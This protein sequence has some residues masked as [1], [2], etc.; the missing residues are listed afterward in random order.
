MQLKKWG[1][2]LVS[3]LLAAGL[4]ACGGGGSNGNN[5]SQSPPASPS[6]SV[7]AEETGDEALTPEPGAK[8]KVWEGQEQIEYMEAIGAEFERQYGV[9]VTF[10]VVAGGDQG[11]RLATDGPAKL[12]GDVLVLPHDQISTAVTAGLLLPND[13]FEEETRNSM[14]ETAIEASSYDGVLYGYPKS[15]ETYA[16]FY[17]KDL[18]PEAPQTWDEIIKFSETFTDP[19]QKKYAIMWE[20]VGFYS[21]PFIGSF[22]GYVF[23]NNN[24][25]P[26]DIGLNNAGA[27][28]GFKFLQTL[29][30]LLPMNAADVTYDIKTQLFLDGKLAFNIDGPWSAG[31]FK[32]KVNFGVAP[33]PAMPN[34]KPSTSFSGVKSY[35]VNSY[36]EYPIAA[37]LFANFAASK[38]NQLKNYE[39]TGAIPAHKEAGE[40]PESQG[41]PVAIGI[42]Q[43]FDNSVPMPG[44]PAFNSVWDPLQ[45]TFISV[46]DNPES[47]VQK[48]L[49]TMV[50]TIKTSIAS[51]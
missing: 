22:G 26:N 36:S 40:V 19:D 17:N 18:Y 11:G 32:D 12:A 27:V 6:A 9:P 3:V 14:L 29:K 45:A 34:G 47:D 2:G 10:E 30:P 5:A 50:N 13:V 15:V 4:T 31:A 24:T 46:W 44:I 42:A 1:V 28:E 48:A 35:Y 8:L 37:R 21:Y 51:K 20:F 43:Q 49:D 41:D 33:L 23:G 7:P 39:M 38:E 16:L 25:D